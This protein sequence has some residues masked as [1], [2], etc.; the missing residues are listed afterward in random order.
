MKKHVWMSMTAGAAMLALAQGGMVFAAA[1]GTGVRAAVAVGAQAEGAVSSSLG[2]TADVRVNAD[3]GAHEQ[4]T[5]TDQQSNVSVTVGS[6]AALN[7]ISAHTGL[8]AAVQAGDVGTS[9]DGAIV[10]LQGNAAALIETSTDLDA[11]DRL[12]V[13]ARP[14]VWN[15]AVEHDGTVAVTYAQPAKFLGLFPATLAGQVDV[16]ASGT[17]VVQLPWYAFLYAQNTSKVQSAVNTAIAASGAD[18][19]V[20]SQTGTSVDLQ[21]K[22][23]IINAVTAALQAEAEANASTSVRTDTATGSVTGQ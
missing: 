10:N 19:G 21:N 15:V 3:T 6:S 2:A 14:A 12:V 9:S 5:A 11:Y 7:A 20:T 23:R 18:F 17:A 4:A 1:A 22:A 16:N 13:A 8:Q